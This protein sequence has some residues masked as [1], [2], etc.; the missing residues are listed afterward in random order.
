MLDIDKIISGSTCAP[1]FPRNGANFCAV[2]LPGP[3]WTIVPAGPQAN[4]HYDFNNRVVTV[5][6]RV[7][8]APLKGPTAEQWG[9]K[10]D[11]THREIERQAACRAAEIEE[12]RYSG[13][14]GGI[15]RLFKL[16]G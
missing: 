9:D 5:P 12:A 13:P 1:P 15:K 8:S 4:L 6:S 11:L 3:D 10:P 2:S 14:F 16:K 7:V